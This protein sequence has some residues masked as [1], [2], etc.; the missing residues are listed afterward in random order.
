MRNYIKECYF[1]NPHNLV[2]GMK[3]EGKPGHDIFN[4]RPPKRI[5]LLNIVIT[6]QC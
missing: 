5:Y 1:G 6:L 4:C 2:E 3:H